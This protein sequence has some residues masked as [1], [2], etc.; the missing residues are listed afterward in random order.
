MTIFDENGQPTLI[1]AHQ[2]TTPIRRRGAVV[3]WKCGR[4]SWDHFFGALCQKTQPDGRVCVGAFVASDK[5]TT[6]GARSVSR[7]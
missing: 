1:G 4:E 6:S 2:E 7:Y 5:Q 3:C